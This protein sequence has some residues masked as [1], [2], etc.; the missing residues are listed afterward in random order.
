LKA[1]RE[2]V[3]ASFTESVWMSSLAECRSVLAAK[4]ASLFRIFSGDY[5][6]QLALLKS[7]LKQPLPKELPARLALVDDVLSA[8]ETQRNFNELKTAGIAAFGAQWNGENS[9]WDR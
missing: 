4:G 6:S 2:T 7:Y 9:D 5:R 3:D 1:L 8:L